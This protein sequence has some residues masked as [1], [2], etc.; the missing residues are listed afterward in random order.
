MTRKFVLLRA[1]QHHPTK[2][3]DISAPTFP[4]PPASNPSWARPGRN[5]DY[6]RLR[7]RRK[8]E[9]RPKQPPEN[10][11]KHRCK[12]RRLH[13]APAVQQVWSDSHCRVHN[14]E[15]RPHSGRPSTQQLSP[16]G[17]A[18]T[19]DGGH[20]THARFAPNS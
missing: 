9:N 6:S 5:A 10:N 12:H 8:R 7:K 18:L 15:G 16:A 3:S 11:Q 1:N 20:S 19:T 14:H 13:Q 17:M 2:W 4:T